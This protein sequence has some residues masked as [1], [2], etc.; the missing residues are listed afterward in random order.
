VG[1]Y[2]E[3]ALKQAGKWEA[4]QAKAILAQNVRQALDYVARGEVDAGFVFATD[5]AIMSDKVKVAARLASPVPV[6]Y[7]IALTAR[8]NQSAQAQAFAKFVLSAEGQAILAKY[9]FGQ[10]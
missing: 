6:L 4:V 9:G 8:G 10:P 1:R 2:T 7:P 5:A 3:A